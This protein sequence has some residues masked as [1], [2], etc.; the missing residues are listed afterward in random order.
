MREK[1][2]VLRLRLQTQKKKKKILLHAL[3][4]TFAFLRIGLS[5]HG[6]QLIMLL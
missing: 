2:P 1:A 4:H 3:S 6:G 5:P